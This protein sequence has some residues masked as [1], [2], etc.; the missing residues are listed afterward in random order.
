MIKIIAFDFVGVLVNEK[1]IELTEI[2]D[3][4]ERMFG[5]NL[6]DSDFLINARK[7]ID[8]DSILMRTT[9]E[10]ISK[11]YKIR[12]KDLFKNIKNKYNNIKIVIATNHVSFVRNFIGETFGVE[13]L[14]DIIISAEIHKIKP[15]SDFYEHIL[16]KYNINAEELLF[17]DD[18]EDN[19][20]GAKK[21][22]INVIKVDKET[23]LSEE[24]FKFINEKD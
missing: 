3:K 10:L 22:G 7:Y 14:D 2:E 16:K 13:D 24:I 12:E 18:N 11:L 4:L 1:D 23:I 6:N 5:P 15:N 20:E 8:K 17:L 9:E 21:L 19:V